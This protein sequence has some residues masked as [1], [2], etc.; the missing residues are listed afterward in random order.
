MIMDAA[1]SPIRFGTDGW[2]GVIADDFTFENLRRAASATAAYAKLHSTLGNGSILI[3]YDRRFMS[4]AFAE[5]TARVLAT[6]K[7]AVQLS[8]QPMPTPAVSF[9]VVHR[10][11]SWGIMITASHNPALYN[12]FKIKDGRGRSAPPEVTREIEPHLTMTG[13]A[14][15]RPT[16]DTPVRTVDDGASYE[17]Y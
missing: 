12:G 10:K 1:A 8:A 2:R 15:I 6:Q 7:I 13:S 3:A 4:R 9:S 5:E 17:S 14:P 11:A 16:A